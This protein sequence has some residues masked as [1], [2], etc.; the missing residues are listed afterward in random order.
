MF[1]VQLNSISQV[2]LNFSCSASQVVYSLLHEIDLSESNVSDRGL[3][4]LSS[5][6]HLR[7]L[8]LNAVKGSRES[9]TS[10][11]VYYS[12]NWLMN[13]CLQVS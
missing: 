12:V 5:C 11:G 13:N 9:V 3:E 8:D 10:A 6:T 4:A 1:S 7:K 2:A